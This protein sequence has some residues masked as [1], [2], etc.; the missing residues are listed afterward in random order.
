MEYLLRRGRYASCVHAGGL[1][2][3]N[4]GIRLGLE[5]PDSKVKLSTDYVL[6]G[7]DDLR[8]QKLL[9][10]VHLVVEGAKFPA[11]R[12]VLAAASP[13]FQAMFTGGFKENQMSEITLNDTSSAGLK[14]VLDAIYTAELSLSEET[15][16]DVFPVASLLQLN[17]IIKHCEIFLSRNISRQTC[18]SFLSVAE[19]YDLQKVVDECNKFVLNNFEIISRLPE[20]KNLSIEQ[21]CTYMSKDCLKTRIGEGHSQMVCCKSKWWRFL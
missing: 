20:L 5:M 14:C 16:C 21:L 13:Y 3:F 19:K 9:C 8:N 17:Q 1:S 2:C 4:L 18:L 10:D 11:H 15:V 12:V 7:L 6:K